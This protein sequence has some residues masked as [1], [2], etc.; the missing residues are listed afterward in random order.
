MSESSLSDYEPDDFSP[1]PP[2]LFCCKKIKLT[3]PRLLMKFHLASNHQLLRSLSRPP[4]LP[5]NDLSQVTPSAHCNDLPRHSLPVRVNKLL[6]SHRGNSPQADIFTVPLSHEVYDTAIASIIQ[7]NGT[8]PTISTTTRWIAILK[9]P[10]EPAVQIPKHKVHLAQKNG[11]LKEDRIPISYTLGDCPK[12]PGAEY[13]VH[14]Y[15]FVS[16]TSEPSPE[17]AAASTSVPQPLSICQSQTTPPTTPQAQLQ[18]LNDKEDSDPYSSSSMHADKSTNTTLGA[19]ASGITYEAL[20]ERVKDG[21]GVPCD[22]C[23]RIR[24]NCSR[25]FL[26][27]GPPACEIC[28]KKDQAC[29]WD[30]VGTGNREGRR[31]GY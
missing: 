7:T 19:T 21:H 24:R 6:F 23:A 20:R 11:Q 15:T 13:Q 18:P 4:A 28:L 14:W 16:P 3:A 10:G 29:T 1:A 26:P 2:P 8:P 5:S 22:G 30:T 31:K 25:R 27:G 17:Q 12:H 9:I